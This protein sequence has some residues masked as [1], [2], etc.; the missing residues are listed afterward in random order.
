MLLLVC[1]TVIPPNAIFDLRTTRDLGKAIAC[2]S[3]AHCDAWLYQISTISAAGLYIAE[4]SLMSNAFENSG[5]LA[6]GVFV[7][8]SLGPC[9][10]IVRS[11]SCRSLPAF[12]AQT[13]AQER[14][15]R[16]RAVK[17]PQISVS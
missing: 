9:G 3:R 4:P 10:S 2:A 15:K 6:R 1:V 8:I 13:Q 12:C 14:K 11:M 5:T 17:P 16:C 7:R